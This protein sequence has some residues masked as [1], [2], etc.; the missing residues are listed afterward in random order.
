MSDPLLSDTE[1]L[2]ERKNFVLLL[3]KMA[4]WKPLLNL[5]AAQLLE[6]AELDA[7]EPNHHF[8][9]R[10]DPF[11]LPDHQFVKL[12]RLNKGLV[13]NIIDRVNGGSPTTKNVCY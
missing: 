1:S 10:G 2:I 9:P 6:D 11:E 8:L 4:L 13:D 12:Y 7:E 5:A 3:Q